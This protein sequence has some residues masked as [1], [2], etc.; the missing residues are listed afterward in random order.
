MSTAQPFHKSNYR[1]RLEIPTWAPPDPE[2]LPV[3][4]PLHLRHSIAELAL[5]PVG[6]PVG[7]ADGYVLHAAGDHTT[8]AYSQVVSAVSLKQSQNNILVSGPLCISPV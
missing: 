1:V 3:T 2:I 6:N 7:A 8:T 5:V 4:R